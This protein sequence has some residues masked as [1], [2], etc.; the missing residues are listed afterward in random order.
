MIMVLVHNLYGIMHL[1]YTSAKC[2]V[3]TAGQLKRISLDSAIMH[4]YIFCTITEEQHNTESKY[5]NVIKLVVNS[6]VYWSI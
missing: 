2:V 5:N 4:I 1:A 3:D 6:N